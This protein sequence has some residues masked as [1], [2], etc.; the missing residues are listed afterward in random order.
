MPGLE[1]SQ[2]SSENLRKSSEIFGNLRKSLE[3]AISDPQGPQ[4]WPGPVGKLIV[5]CYNIIAANIFDA[6]VITDLEKSQKSRKILGNLRKSL[7]IFG[8]LWKSRCRSD[9]DRRA[10]PDWSE[11]LSMRASLRVC[12]CVCPLRVPATTSKLRGSETRSLYIPA[13]GAQKH[14]GRPKTSILPLIL[15]FMAP[16]WLRAAI[17]CADF[18]VG[19]EILIVPFGKF[20][21]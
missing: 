18:R 7:E 10:D 19:L 15:V 20:F 2:K 16:N 8:N 5:E 12:E 9:S 11:R 4:G 14:A 21:S 6:R 13:Q 17:C 3:V 1:N